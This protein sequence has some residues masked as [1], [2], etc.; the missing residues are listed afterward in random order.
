MSFAQSPLPTPKWEWE[1]DSEAKPCAFLRFYSSLSMPAVLALLGIA[2]SPLTGC[3]FSSNT[4]SLL[5]VN[6]FFRD[7]VTITLNLFG[8]YFRPLDLKR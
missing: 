2:P 5:D 1:V 3:A 7:G 8:T 4:L 6:I